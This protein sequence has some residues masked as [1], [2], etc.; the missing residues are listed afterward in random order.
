V[1][2]RMAASIATRT[3]QRMGVLRHG[4]ILMGAIV[5]TPRAA[6]KVLDSAC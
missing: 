6:I 3:K 4:V 2:S 5:P 1:A